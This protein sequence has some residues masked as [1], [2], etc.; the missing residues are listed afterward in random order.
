MKYDV[1]G[2]LLLL[3]LPYVCYLAWY[4][5]MLPHVYILN[6][7]FHIYLILYVRYNDQ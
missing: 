4:D 7:L 2:F 5:F 6:V 1:F 3:S